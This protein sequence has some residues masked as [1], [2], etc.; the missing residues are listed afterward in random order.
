M[1][2][3]VARLYCIGVGFLFGSSSLLFDNFFEGLC[4]AA[5]RANGYFWLIT[6]NF[7][8]S[9]ALLVLF[10]AAPAQWLSRSS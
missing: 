1:Q 2:D 7:A 9:T 6:G 10:I 5:Y 3:R 8:I 4:P